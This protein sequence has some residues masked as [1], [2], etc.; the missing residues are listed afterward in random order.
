MVS[1]SI[2]DCP[3]F[4]GTLHVSSDLKLENVMLGL[5]GHVCL[6]DFG[7]CKEGVGYDGKTFSYCGTPG[8]IWLFCCGVFMP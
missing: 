8:I 4:L 2:K 5:E 3:R 7:L 1:L 6:T